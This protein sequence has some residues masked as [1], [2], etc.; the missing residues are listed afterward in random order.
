MNTHSG[1]PEEFKGVYILKMNLNG[2]GFGAVVLQTLNQIRYCERNSLLPV[3]N[4]DQSCE[5]HF[6]DKSYGENTWTQYFEALVP[7][8][9]FPTIMRYCNGQ[10]YSISVAELQSLED[11][12]VI[13]M[14]EHHEDSIYTFTFADWRLNPPEDLNAW[15]NKQREKGRE[16]FSKYIRVKPSILSRINEFW[17]VHLA[18]HQVLGVHVRGTDLMY[19]PPVSPAEYFEHIDQWIKSRKHPKLFVATD[20]TQYL[21]TFQSRYGD[22]VVAYDSSRSVDEVVPFN[23]EGITP[24]KKGEDV[25]FDMCLLSKT[26]FLIKGTSAVSEL[27]L[28][29]NPKLECLDLSISKRFAFGQDYGKGWNG[30]LLKDTK[31]AWLLLKNTD[32]SSIEG[33]AR[34]QTPWQEF[35]YKFRPLYSPP[36]IFFK[37][38]K[39]A[40]L[41]R[42]GLKK[43]V[44]INN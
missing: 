8:Y 30:G 27:A 38:V 1:I 43:T 14:C 40:V 35:L 32:L 28:Y 13:Q 10:E 6:F 4:Y 36:I 15:Y 29:M 42:L 41:R 44:S 18:G 5:G 2:A 19:A 20:Q 26:D 25:L 24:Y 23:L 11:K 17:D 37:R 16:T 21:S 3:V 39:N 31:P 34:T 7:P 12:E 9:D 33:S 22:L